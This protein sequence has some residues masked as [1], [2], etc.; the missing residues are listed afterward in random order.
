M[1]SVLS[2]RDLIAEIVRYIWL[3]IGCAILFGVLLGGYKYAKDLSASKQVVEEVALEDRFTEE[4][5]HQINTYAALK[6]RY[7]NYVQ[8]VYSIPIMELNA[9]NVDTVSLQYV[10]TAQDL[11]EKDDVVS[12][13]TGYILNGNLA[14]DVAH[15]LNMEASDVQF[16]IRYVSR[17]SY[18]VQSEITGVIELKLWGR[19]AEESTELAKAVKE[20]IS[21]YGNTLVNSGLSH[22]V[23]LVDESAFKMYDN[24]L[25]AEQVTYTSNI[26][27]ELTFVTNQ[28]TK[29][30]SAQLAAADELIVTDEKDEEVKE[31]TEVVTPKVGISKK[32][33]VLGILLGGVAAA[34]LI[35]AWY[36]L[37]A[38]IKFAE[39]IRMVYGVRYLGQISFK[40]KNTFEVLADK[41]FYTSKLQSIE[42]QKELLCSKILI[43]C[44]TEGIKEFVLSGEFDKNKDYI[45]ELQKKLSENGISVKVVGDILSQPDALNELKGKKN[46]IFVETIKKSRYENVHQEIVLC[47]EQNINVLGYII[48]E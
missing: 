27:K 38:T 39:E 5:I 41:L 28:E 7:L 31:E 33:I 1:R 18:Y 16:M 24:E 30:N 22:G 6:N 40:K 13:Y 3:V 42:N 43:T 17:D 12:S 10:V 36:I 44:E 8:H 37:T 47:D 48:F 21:S 45:H 19:T 2:I 32:F 11:N 4:E 35:V 23:E 29:L 20:C 9:H 25:Y 15:E 46:I 14:Q 26:D 34:G